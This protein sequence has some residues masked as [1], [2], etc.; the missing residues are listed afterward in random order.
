MD[1]PNKIYRCEKCKDT[2]VVREKDG[3]FH[4][5]WKCLEEGKMEQHSEKLPESRIKI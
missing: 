2:G 5:C 4:T 1:I 3:T